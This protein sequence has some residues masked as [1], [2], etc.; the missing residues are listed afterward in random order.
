MLNFLVALWPYL[1]IPQGPPLSSHV[2]LQT[3]GSL[4]IMFPVCG[5]G[6]GGGGVGGLHTES[7]L[8]V[9]KIWVW[10]PPTVSALPCVVHSSSFLRLPHIHFFSFSKKQRNRPKNT[11]E[12]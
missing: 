3:E 7:A 1:P 8:Q 2:Q 5:V 6:L 4:F 11:I 9:E 12:A 10:I